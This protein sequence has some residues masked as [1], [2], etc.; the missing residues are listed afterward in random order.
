MLK[1]KISKEDFVKYIKE[2]QEVSKLVHKVYEASGRTIDIINLEDEFQM[3]QNLHELEDELNKPFRIIERN[4]FTKVEL[5]YISWF[6]YEYKSGHMKIYK[7]GTD[8]EVILA[9]LETIDD[10]WNWLNEE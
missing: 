1:D 10:L 6:L 8:K 4:F 3:I 7:A 9:D 2:S 5:D